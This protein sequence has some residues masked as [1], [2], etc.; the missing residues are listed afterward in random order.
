MRTPRALPIACAGDAYNKMLDIDVLG[1]G[2]LLIDFTPF[3]KGDTGNPA[4]EMNPGGA[5]ANCLAAL[6]KL[7]ARTEFVGKIGNDIFGAFL[8]NIL[9]K[10]GIG[11]KGLSVTDEVPTTLAF[12]HLS[13]EGERSFSFLR[14]PGGA[15][16][17]LEIGDIDLSLIER[18]RIVHFGSLSFTDNPARDTV[19]Y[20]LEYA[21]KSGKIISYDPNYRPLLWK[22]E[23]TALDWINVGF[24]YADIVK[25]SEEEVTFITGLKDMKAA[26]K[27]IWLLGCKQVFVT[28]GS[29]GAYYFAGDEDNGFVPA[30]KV[31]VKDTTGCGDAFMGAVLYQ[32]IYYSTNNIFETV[33]CANAVGALCATKRG[34]IP[35]MPTIMDVQAMGKELWP[36][37]Q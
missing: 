28:M 22:D 15:D 36:S 2:E 18:S 24:K 23:A 17:R 21:K 33:K 12:V 27:K 4:F 7:G 8:K 16:T 30:F 19:L 31:R 3:G 13:D 5:P 1:I 25:L 35:A 29:N 20:V 9:V 32:T 6:N 10:E 26:A 14:N 11:V 37:T 34:G